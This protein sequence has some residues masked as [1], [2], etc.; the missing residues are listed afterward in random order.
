M[1]VLEDTLSNSVQMTEGRA[2]LAENLS[3]RRWSC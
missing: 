3:Q 2:T 1:E